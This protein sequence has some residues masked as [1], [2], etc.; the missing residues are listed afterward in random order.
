MTLRAGHVLELRLDDINVFV[1]IDFDSGVDAEAP[2]I[3]K[4]W[5][6]ATCISDFA[7]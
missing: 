3:C 6:N 7:S 1:V 4:P 5:T 2:V